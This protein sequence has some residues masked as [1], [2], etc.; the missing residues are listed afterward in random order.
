MASSIIL[1]KEPIEMAMNGIY[2]LVEL[3]AT[4]SEHTQNKTRGRRCDEAAAISPIKYGLYYIWL[5]LL[6]DY[7][8][9]PRARYQ[10]TAN[11]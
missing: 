8:L 6:L 2:A 1:I 4:V 11:S 5:T 10:L 3:K 7:L 9:M